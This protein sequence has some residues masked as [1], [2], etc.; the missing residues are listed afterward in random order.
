M[1]SLGLGLSVSRPQTMLN[2]FDVDAVAFFDRASITD[3]TQKSAI[4]TLVR[5]L[6][7]ASLWS[8]MTALY[9][10]VGGNATAHSKNLIANQYNITW[11]GTVAHNSDGVTSNGSTGYGSTNMPRSALPLVE[12]HLAGY[13]QTVASEFDGTIGIDDGGSGHFTELYHTAGASTEFGNNTASTAAGF[14]SAPGMA[15][16]TRSA[17]QDLFL[18]PS[19]SSF[20]TN[21]STALSDHLAGNFFILAV[22]RNGSAALFCSDTHSLISA[23]DALSLAEAIAYREIVTTFQTALGRNV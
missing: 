1:P 18:A 8:K 9:P 13:L 14:A 6:K 19:Q 5:D 7:A 22:N 23:G 11:N 15:I 10:F 2:P 3:G 16:G 4:D 17:T 12:L 21:T 20:S